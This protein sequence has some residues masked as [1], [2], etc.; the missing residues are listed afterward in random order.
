MLKKFKYVIIKIMKNLKT[1]FSVIYVTVP[2]AEN[3]KLIAR[4]L[5]K[6]RL[7]AS[8]N[9]VGPNCSMY[10]SENPS[11]NS[12][13]VEV[14]EFFLVIK[15]LTSLVDNVYSNVLKLNEYDC[16]SIINMPIENGEEHFLS[17][18]AKTLAQS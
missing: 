11:S 2:N 13:I 9:I 14:S 12:S 15:T 10:K 8:V 3:A 6:N 4:S 18:I 7:A 17:W 16:P 1:D 5:I